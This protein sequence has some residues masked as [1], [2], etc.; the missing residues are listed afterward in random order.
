MLHK[1]CI[2][3][4]R[5]LVSFDDDKSKAYGRE[6]IDK[7]EEWVGLFESEALRRAVEGIK[8]EGNEGGGGKKK[9]R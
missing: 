2:T 4:A 3:I 7:V 1:Q 8:G 6:W 9:K 5:A